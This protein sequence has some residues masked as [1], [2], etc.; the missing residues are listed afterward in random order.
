MVLMVPPK[1]FSNRNA[2][3]TESGIDNSTD[4]VPRTEPRKINTI[5]AVSTNPMAISRSTLLMAVFTYCD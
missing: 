2:A 1:A 5:A 3:S 4:I